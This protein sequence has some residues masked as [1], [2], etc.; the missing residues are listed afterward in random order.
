MILTTEQEKVV[1]GILERYKNKEKY[2]ILCGYAGTGKSTCVRFIVE[3]LISNFHIREEDIC[4]CA[5][6]GKAAQV[7]LKKGNKN[8]STLHH[9]MYESVPLSDGTFKHIP[10]ARI[11]YKI[12][13]IDEISMVPDSMWKQLLK[14]SPHIIGMGDNFQLPPVDAKEDN[15]LLNSPHFFLDTVLRQAQESEIIRISMDL[16][17]GKELTP[18]MGEE[19]RIYTQ[20]EFSSSMLLWADQILVATNSTR[21][22]LNMI[23]K[24]LLGRGD[25]PCEGDKVICLKNYWGTLSGNVDPLVNGT[26]GYLIAPYS[27]FVAFPK[28][29]GG[30]KFETLNCSITTDT[31]DIFPSLSLDKKM[32]LTGEKCCD[33]KTAWRIMQSEQSWKMP[34]EFAYG[35]AITYWKAQGS[36]WDKVLIVEE[37]FPFDKEVHQKAMYTAITRATEKAVIIKK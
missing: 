30:K 1:K 18:H 23:T 31:G 3:A 37:N 24:K 19:V 33:F 13:V 6:T 2:S 8:V 7:L 27:S 35:Y 26:I 32:I 16:R 21:N 15:G 14:Y 5:Y 28:R 36:E 12:L 4:Y 9:L 11:P 20:N 29:L 17:A 25:T 34:K 10:V 22:N